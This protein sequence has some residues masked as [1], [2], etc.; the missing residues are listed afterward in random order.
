MQAKVLTA[1]RERPSPTSLVSASASILNKSNLSGHMMPPITRNVMLL[2]P[3]LKFHELAFCDSSPWCWQGKGKAPR[4][5]SPPSQACADAFCYGGD[6]RAP[7]LGS[8]CL[9]FR[10]LRVTLAALRRHTICSISQVS[11]ARQV[12]A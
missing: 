9:L 11:S 1:V 3:A 12:C 5:P 4:K 7:F 8:C 2:G 6:Y 10:L